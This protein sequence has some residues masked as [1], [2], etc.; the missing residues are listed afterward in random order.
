MFFVE[1]LWHI[2]QTAWC[3][4]D[5][6]GAA[7]SEWHKYVCYIMLHTIV[8]VCIGVHSQATSMH[9]ALSRTTTNLV[10]TDTIS[11]VDHSTR[12]R[13]KILQLKF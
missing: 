12:S 7:S 13:Y 6:A 10:C 3:I 1:H 2:R 5:A 9:T 8:F 4:T 11:N